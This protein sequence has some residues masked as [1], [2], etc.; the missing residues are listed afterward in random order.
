MPADRFS[1]EK[2]WGNAARHDHAVCNRQNEHGRRRPPTAPQ[3][4]HEAVPVRHLVVPGM[5]GLILGSPVLYVH[6]VHEDVCWNAPTYPHLRFVHRARA[7]APLSLLIPA[8]EGF[9]RR[10]PSGQKAGWLLGRD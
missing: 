10:L 4:L 7:P 5:V 1:R 9:P 3:H 6:D 8:D 2:G